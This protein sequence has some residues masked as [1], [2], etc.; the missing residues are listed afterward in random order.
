M[1]DQISEHCDLGKFTYKTD[2]QTSQRAEG[3]CLSK[4]VIRDGGRV[5][6]E[7][8][9]PQYSN[10]KVVHV[11]VKLFQLYSFPKSESFK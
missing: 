11:K 3:L 5:D 6:G 7:G 9:R 4:E 8:T 2:H 10:G 1:F